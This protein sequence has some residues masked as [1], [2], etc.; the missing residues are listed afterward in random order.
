MRTASS[1][2]TARMMGAITSME[3]SNVKRALI[4]RIVGVAIALSVGL[5]ITKPTEATES[6]PADTASTARSS[7]IYD[8]ARARHT[9]SIASSNTGSPSHVSALASKLGLKEETLSDALVAVRDRERLTSNFRTPGSKIAVSNGRGG[10]Q[11]AV[12]RA[13]ADELRLDAPRVLAS[14]TELQAEL[15]ART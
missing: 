2:V 7:A 3:G 9:A 8:D 12:S 5:G 4:A 6:S 13:L 15:R 14:L 11:A 10:R 1:Q